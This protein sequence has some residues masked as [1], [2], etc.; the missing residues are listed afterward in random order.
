MTQMALNSAYDPLAPLQRWVIYTQTEILNLKEELRAAKEEEQSV[1]N[2]QQRQLDVLTAQMRDVD[3][4]LCEVTDAVTELFN[5]QKTVHDLLSQL[6]RDI[7]ALKE[8]SQQ[9]DPPMTVPDTQP[10][11]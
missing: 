11:C 10:Y 1:R 7:S 9:Q 8:Q 6:M 5:K 3:Q 2:L 4:R